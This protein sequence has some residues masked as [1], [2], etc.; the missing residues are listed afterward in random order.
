M[1][2]DAQTFVSESRKEI[3]G[4]FDEVSKFNTNSDIKDILKKI[5]AYSA[6]A[7]YMAYQASRSHNPEVV[8][9]KE[10]E[11]DKF[12]KEVEFQFRVWSRFEAVVSREWEMVK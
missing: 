4:Y 12:L 11:L 8:Q 6:R 2:I 9:F 5:S 10:N 3:N 7:S 1:A